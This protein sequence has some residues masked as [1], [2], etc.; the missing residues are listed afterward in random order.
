MLQTCDTAGG[1]I[2]NHSASWHL[3]PPAPFHFIAAPP[4]QRQDLS[5]ARPTSRP[6]S[7][8]D[9]RG[10]R[11]VHNRNRWMDPQT[12][13]WELPRIPHAV[14]RR[15]SEC[16]LGND[17]QRTLSRKRV[18]ENQTCEIRLTS[19]GKNK[20]WFSQDSNALVCLHDQ[21]DHVTRS[22]VVLL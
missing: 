12:L 6:A 19:V 21:S 4:P 20:S 15:Q 10:T 1:R 2:P 17:F 13:I 16:G 3:F 9:K 11:C 8:P 18:D 5:C 22:E 7:V 14:K